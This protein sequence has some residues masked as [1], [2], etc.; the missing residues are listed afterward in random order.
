MKIIWFDIE[1]YSDTN[2]E[3]LL[4]TFQSQLSESNLY[5]IVQ[6]LNSPLMFVS[7]L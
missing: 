1:K 5:K 7:Q 3:N 4:Q 2:W 6:L